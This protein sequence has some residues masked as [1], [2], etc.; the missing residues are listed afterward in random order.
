[1][2]VKC[3]LCILPLF[4]LTSADNVGWKSFLTESPAEFHDLPL[5]WE[6]GNQTKVPNWL[7]GVF[8][9]N[10]PSQVSLMHITTSLKRLSDLLSARPVL[11]DIMFVK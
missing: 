10:G 5:E 3:F 7:S 1:M 4:L 2:G 8:V 9:R 11:I 6:T